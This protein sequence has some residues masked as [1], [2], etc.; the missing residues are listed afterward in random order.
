LRQFA[1][2]VLPKQQWKRPLPSPEAGG[3]A[4]AENPVGSSRVKKPS[5]SGLRTGAPRRGYFQREPGYRNFD[6]DQIAIPAKSIII[7]SRWKKSG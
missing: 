2:W 5:E 7:K 4:A 1:G 3:D 6:L